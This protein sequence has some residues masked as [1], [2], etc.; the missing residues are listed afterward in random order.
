MATIDAQALLSGW[1]VSATRMDEFTVVADLTDAAAQASP[2]DEL[3]VERACA[4]ILAERPATASALLEDVDREAAVAEATTWKDVVALAAWAARG[5]RDALASLLRA[6][7]RLQGQHVAPHAYLLAAAA[8]Q[9]GQDD[10]ADSAWR[11]VATSATPTMVVLRRRAVADVLRRS[12]TSPSAAAATVE[13]AARAVAGMYPQPEDHL[14]PTLDVVERLEA[15]DDRAGAR[16]LLEAMVALRPDVAGL[17]A[18]LDER[19]PAAAPLRTTV[20]RATA[21]VVAAAL[22]ALSVTQGLTSLVAGAGIV[23]AGIVW[24]LAG[25]RPTAGLTRTDRRAVWRVRQ[26]LGDD[27]QT[28]D[29]LTRRVLGGVVGAALLVVPTVMTLGGLA[30]DPLADVGQTPE[31]SA[32]SFC[33]LTLVAC[34]GVAAGQW[35]LKAGIRLTARKRRAQ[36]QSAMS[37]QARECLCLGTIGLR[38]T[39]ADTYL[40]AHLVPAEAD[41]EALVPDL[42]PAAGSGHRCPVSDTPWLAVRAPGRATLLVRGVLARVPEPVADAAGGYI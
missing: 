13:A 3:A 12:T 5:D 14:H 26:L 22:V 39:E 16:L 27:D 37:S 10:V 1:A 6:G 19:A 33:V 23:A 2:G 15:R 18:L 30:E 7:G 36:Q 31:F 41:V 25:Q 17:R 11:T 32:A 40:D 34:L 9:A 35:R 24:A 8:E 42:S 28:L 21:V 20:L 29:P 38:G 4:A